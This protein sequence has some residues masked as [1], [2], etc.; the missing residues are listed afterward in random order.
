MEF[1]SRQPGFYALAIL[2]VM[3]VVSHIFQQKTVPNQV[4]DIFETDHMSAEQFVQRVQYLVEEIR[5]ATDK[6]V[7]SF[8]NSLIVAFCE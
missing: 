1:A 3:L 2:L 4:M 8:V 5:E 6:Q 7:P